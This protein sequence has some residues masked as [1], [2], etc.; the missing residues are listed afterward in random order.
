MVRNFLKTLRVVALGSAM[1]LT[2]NAAFAADTNLPLGTLWKGEA[3]AGSPPWVNVLIRT[4]SDAAPG[5]YASYEWIRYTLE[6]QVTTDSAFHDETPASCC[7]VQGY[8]HLSGR[9]TLES[10]YLNLNPRL[11]IDK[12][13]IYWTGAPMAAG[14]PGSDTFPAAG[15]RPSKIRIEAN[16]FGLGAAGKFDIKLEWDGNTKLGPSGV[17]WSK[18]LFVYGDGGID[19]ALLPSDIQVMSRNARSGLAPFIAAGH[20]KHV[21]GGDEAWIK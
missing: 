15:L 11:D 16:E 6:V 10:L 9:E 7:G 18:L 4:F 19:D 3:P 12:L 14:Q 5:A 13:R 17:S 1:L 8:G 21:D 20:I 2:A